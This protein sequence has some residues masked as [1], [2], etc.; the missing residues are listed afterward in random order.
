MI[1]AAKRLGR[2]TFL[3]LVTNMGTLA[4]APRIAFAASAHTDRRFIFIIQRG[5][6]DG[7][8]ALVPVGDPD[9]AR[10]RAGLALD[11]AN[12][13]KLDGTF[14]LHP[15]LVE[16]SKMYQA[17][18][19]LFAHA[20]ASPYRDRSHFDAQNIIECGSAAPY[21]LRDGWMNRLAGLL[22]KTRTPPTAFTPTVP[23]ALRGTQRVTLRPRCRARV[24]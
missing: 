2:R 3:S 18:E 24:T 12:V 13:I 6:A 16:T 19:V 4:L 5:A 1:L 20:V 17:G 11:P 23:M 10:V 15:A 7:L 8:E 21:A 9:Y 22:P 14:G